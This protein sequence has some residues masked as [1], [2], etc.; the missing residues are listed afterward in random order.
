[1][2][3]QLTPAS[4]LAGRSGARTV[5]PGLE[6]PWL[7]GGPGLPIRSALP[8]TVQTS[9]VTGRPSAQE[10]MTVSASSTSRHC[11]DVPRTRMPLRL[12]FFIRHTPLTV[13]ALP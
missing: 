3:G 11:D 8:H 12:V 2:G 13:I 4:S 10:E 5:Y 9:E 6:F 7:V 1:M